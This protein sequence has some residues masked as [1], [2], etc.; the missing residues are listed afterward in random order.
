MGGVKGKDTL[1]AY[2]AIALLEAGKTD[3]ADKAITYLEGRLGDITDPYALALTT[4]ALRAGQEPGGAAGDD[5]AHGSRPSRTRTASIG[6]APAALQPLRR[7]RRAGEPLGGRRRRG[8]AADEPS[9]STSSRAWTS[10]PPATRRWPSSPSGD[11]VN[12]ARAAKWLVG[13]RN[14]QG[15]FGSTQDTVVALQALTEYATSSA[16]DTNMTVTVKAGDVTKEIK[17]TPDNFDV[18][19]VVEVPAGVPVEL[20]AKGKGEAVVQGVLRYNLPDAPTDRERVRHQ[21]GLQHRP[22]GGE[23]P[24]RHQGERDLQP[25]GAHQGRHGGGGHLGAH[26]LRRRGGLAGEAAGAAQRSSATTWPAAR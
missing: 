20:T 7:R 3:A 18:T 16:T 1:T 2:V 12:A 21:G 14:S 19:Q 4:Y 10:R 13:Q 5:Q 26:R 9:R 17:I 11:R 23:R 25:A 24:D 6:A 8:A 22:G 15:G